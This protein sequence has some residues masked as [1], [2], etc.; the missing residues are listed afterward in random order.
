MGIES[1]SQQRT[2]HASGCCSVGVYWGA[3]NPPHPARRCV[4]PAAWLALALLLVGPALAGMNWKNVVDVPGDPFFHWEGDAGPS[5]IKFT[6]LTSAPNTV[7]FQDSNLYLFHYDFATTEL[8]PFV[9]MSQEDFDNATLHA[10]GQ[11]GILGAVLIPPTAAGQH[12]TPEYGIQLVRQDPYAATEA[13]D[14]L[15]SVAASLN[16]QPGYQAYYM[17]TLEQEAVAEANADFFA[18]EGFPVSSPARWNDGNSCYSHGW[19]IGTLKYFPADQIESAFLAGQ[20]TPDDILLTD[21]VPAEIPFLAGVLSLGPGTPN[22]HVALLSQTFGVP[23]AYLA[24][25]PDAQKAQ[26][27]VGHR[28]ALRVLDNFGACQVRIVDTDDELDQAT[29]DSL[30]ALKEP[31]PLN[32]S[33]MQTYGAYSAPTDGLTPADIQYFGGKAANTGILRQ[34]IPANTRVST[35]FSFDLWNGFLDQLLANSNTLRQEIAQILAPFSYPPDMQA[36]DDALDSIR[37]LIKDTDETSFSLAL[38]TA[39]LTTLQDPQYG[40]DPFQKLRFRSST[41]VE[42]SDQFTGAGL[43]DSFSGCLADDLDA[44]QTGPSLCDPEQSSER[45]V[46]RAIRKVFASFYNFNAYLERLRYGVNENEVGMA[47]LVHHSFP[48]PIELAN[49]VATFNHGPGSLKHAYLVLQPGANSVTNPEPGQ[50]PEE[51]DVTI[52]GSGAIYP[53]VV[54]YSNLL[55][56]GDTVLE[57]TEEYETLTQLLIDA[58]DHYAFVTGLSEFVLEYEFK[59]IEPDDHLVVTQVRRVPQADDTPTLT[60][61]LLNEP[62]NYC[63][64]QGEGGGTVFATHR[65]KSQWTVETD[66][67]WLTAE[68]LGVGFFDETSLEYLEGCLTFDQQGPLSGWPGF[69]HGYTSGTS[70]EDWNFADLQNARD[71]GL[72][73]QQIPELLSEA[74]GPLR[75]L[76][77]FGWPFDYT[78]LGC[79]SI[80]VDYETPLPDRDFSG[81][82]TTTTDFGKLCR[83]PPIEISDILKTRSGTDGGITIDTQ[84]YWPKPVDPGAGYTAPLS[85][86]VQTTISGLASQP[87]VLTGYYSQTYKPGHHNFTAEFLFEP[88]LEPGLPQSTLDELAAADVR[89]L[90]VSFGFGNEVTV[91]TYGEAA[92]G[93]HCLACRGPDAD[94]DGQCLFDPTF[95]C[96]DSNGSIWAAPG[97]VPQLGFDASGSFLQWTAP[98]E[99]GGTSVVYDTLRADD[100]PDFLGASCV[101]SD[102][103]SDLQAMTPA[104]PDPG[105]VFHYLVRAENDCPDGSGSLG[106]DSNGIDRVGAACP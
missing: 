88:A 106:Q 46:F 49:G 96:D 64:F 51:V 63:L 42:D 62:V 23:Y 2:G 55:Q 81:P 39:V 31:P 102:D 53:F 101:E 94:G 56:L 38:Q 104:E 4:E 60:P 76:T 97:E 83:C 86:F 89:A 71:Y 35:A 36:L 22:S 14:I 100:T 18:A 27:L 72:T 48:D 16:L 20:L 59:K 79:L 37:D 30:L 77:D 58:A 50:V 75:L 24:L 9:G 105:A 28:A 26:D 92:W 12:V 85:R 61:F 54:Q 82:T 84:Y 21:A 68:N 69:Q 91:T 52:S 95:D 13:R 32:I 70:T 19:A 90:Y 65:L 29:V 34:S 93:Y 33:P 11:L 78:D 8:P 47:L 99:L 6:I 17:P 45:G 73:T 44:N 57:F 3:M 5:W 15:Q 66:S 1:A 98:D 74:Q 41:N 40:F 67:L 87:I 25:S 80:Q 43:Y 103:G 7:Y 10:A